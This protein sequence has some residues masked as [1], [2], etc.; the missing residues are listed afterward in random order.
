MEDSEE[1]EEEVQ[2][3]KWSR[4]AGG[5]VYLLGH[6]EKLVA[7]VAVPVIA[8]F[9]VTALVSAFALHDH[10]HRKVFVGS[11]GLVASVAMACNGFDSEGWMQDYRL[12]GTFIASNAAVKE[13]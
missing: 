13:H 3:L 11:V 12:L 9:C 7:L 4:N 5:I 1:A 2:F 8:T 10:H 6:S